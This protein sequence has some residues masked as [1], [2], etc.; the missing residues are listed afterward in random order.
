MVSWRDIRIDF[1][2]ALVC[3]ILGRFQE[4]G[5]QRMVFMGGVAS[6]SADMEAMMVDRNQCFEEHW[7]YKGR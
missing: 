1:G 4:K 6:P 2:R 3:F 7:H 5:G